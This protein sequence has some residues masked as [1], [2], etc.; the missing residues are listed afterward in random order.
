MEQSGS[1][2]T[3]VLSFLGTSRYDPVIYEWP[4]APREPKRVS[5]NMM[6]EAIALWFP[7]ARFKVA[8][9][10]GART[11]NWENLCRKFADLRQLHGLELNS[12]EPIDIP[13][14][15]TEQEIWQIFEAIC[16]AIEDARD[17]VIDIT[18]AFRSIPLLAVMSVLYAQEVGERMGFPRVRHVLYGA[19]VPGKPS[20]ASAGT[21]P[22]VVPVL[23]LIQLVRLAEWL[24]AAH[25]FVKAGDAR[26][27]GELARDWP[28]SGGAM[29]KIGERLHDVSVAL[30]LSRPADVR[31]RLAELQK[32]VDELSPVLDQVGG[33]LPE[34]LRSIPE[35]YR[36]LE[37]CPQPDDCLKA[38]ELD[39]QVIDWYIDAGKLAQ[40]FALA[41]EWLTTWACCATGL[42]YRRLENRFCAEDVL[43]GQRE[44]DAGRRQYEASLA[45]T[46]KERADAL[47]S[48]V[49]K[50]WRRVDQDVRKWRNE[51]AHCGMGREELMEPR[52]VE[53][54]AR[55]MPCRLRKL[56]YALANNVGS[57][58]APGAAD[59]GG[60]SQ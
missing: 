46:A 10:E 44:G 26:E 59:G 48:W 5:T 14:G 57:A 37:G 58:D 39:L 30:E 38:L 42:D 34:V 2:R 25:L 41:G 12:P 27:I 19:F 47:D 53:D 8:L 43:R 40:A 1:G 15:R 54:G 33:P 56:Y 49:V 22:P 45:E 31:H 3:V 50:E 24:K 29:Q 16:D 28:D 11:E 20:A 6:L 23:D 17:L 21:E 18:H 55:K 32:E 4:A 36:N 35:R 7:D 9:T 51:I 13:D 52:E 60:R